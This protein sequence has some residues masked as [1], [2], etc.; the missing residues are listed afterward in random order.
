VEKFLPEE[1]EILDVVASSLPGNAESVARPFTAIVINVNACS[2]G[3]RDRQDLDFCLVI[4]IGT[5]TGGALVLM[6]TG[7][8]LYLRQGDIV[9]FRS[10]DITHLNLHYQGKRSSIVLHS[11]KEMRQWVREQNGWAHNETMKTY[12]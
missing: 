4:P 1:Y 11:D 5:F 9:I 12:L 10:G 8:V 3:H 7:L 2:K 6:E